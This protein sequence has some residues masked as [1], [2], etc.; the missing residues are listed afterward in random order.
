MPDDNSIS[1]VFFRED[2]YYIKINEKYLNNLIILNFYNLLHLGS[3]L[4][5]LDYLL[6][7]LRSLIRVVKEDEKKKGGCKKNIK[8][9]YFAISCR[10][11]KFACNL[12][13]VIH[14]I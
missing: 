5:R 3:E 4:K 12:A 13:G 10:I 2:D 11:M 6:M 7:K 8:G 1:Q 9:L 14:L